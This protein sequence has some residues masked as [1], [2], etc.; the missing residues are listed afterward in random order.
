[1]S[2]N[3]SRDFSMYDEMATEELE[4]ILRADVDAPEGAESDIDMILYVMEVLARR[5]EAE[6]D[7]G[8]TALEA[9]QSFRENYM[10]AAEERAAAKPRKWLRS[11][12][13]VAAAVVALVILGSVSA[14][15]FG[16]SFWNAVAKWTQETFHFG[17]NETEL[18]EPEVVNSSA[19]GDLWDAMVDNGDDPTVLPRE[20]LEGFELA[21]LIVDVTPRQRN[22]TV[23]YKNGEERIKVTALSYIDSRPEQFE[24]SEDVTEVYEKSGSLYYIVS[25]HEQVRVSWVDGKYEC[26][27]SG[28]VS[29]DELKLMIDSIE[30]G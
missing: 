28:D 25:N 11:L 5:R 13:T 17:S 2:E 1:M 8:K 23:V 12:T 20:M 16:F 3:R 29:I 6:G 4:E 14:N 30:K 27:I 15:A 21:E 19:T 9:Y 22:Y 10:P 18:D 24:Q 26:Y 7:T